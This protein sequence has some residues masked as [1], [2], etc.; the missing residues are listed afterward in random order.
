VCDPDG[1][2]GL[3][4]YHRYGLWVKKDDTKAIAL[5][6]RACLLLGSIAHSHNRLMPGLDM[7]G[8]CLAERN[9][10]G[11]VLIDP[12]SAPIIFGEPIKAPGVVHASAASV[13]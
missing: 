3:A 8:F 6:E 7:A 1:L 10:H 11:I 13:F 2:D 5:E 4:Y 9:R 12:E